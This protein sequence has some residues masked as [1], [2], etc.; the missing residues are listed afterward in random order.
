MLTKLRLNQRLLLLW[1]ASAAAVLFVSGFAYW[2]LQERQAEIDER[3]RIET[4]FGILG[5]H[6]GERA[7]RLATSA[8]ALAERASVVA[9]LRLFADYFDPQ[10]GAATFD[11]PA[12]E[13]AG[14]LA[15]LARA[16]GAG[17]AV[18]VGR[19]GP[20]SGYWRDDATDY[21]AYFSYPDTGVVAFSSARGD[22]LFRPLA[23]APGFLGKAEGPADAGGISMV[24]CPTGPGPALLAINPV[25]RSG[26]AKPDSLLGSVHVG[27]CLDREFIERVASQTDTAF[28]ILSGEQFTRSGDRPDSV[29]SAEPLPEMATGIPL[30]A[31]RWHR[32]HRRLVGAGDWLLDDGS[33]NVAQFTLDRADPTAQHHALITAGLSGLLLSGL[34]IFAIGLL[35]LRRTVTQPLQQ[36]MRAVHSARQG[37]YEAV[38]GIRPGDEIGDLA[39]TFN[40]MT[41]R[42]RRREEELRRLSRAVE[43]SPASVVITD[44]EGH[45][46]YVNPRFSEVTGYTS[47][48]VLGHKPNLLKSGH[49]SD[50]VYARLWQTILA[51]K[52]WRGELFNRTKDGTVICEQTSISPIFGEDGIITHFVAVNEDITQRKQAEAQINHLAYHDGLTDLPNRVLFRDRLEQALRLYRRHGVPFALLLLDLDHFKDINDSLGHT[53]GDG[54]LRLVARRVDGLLRKSDTFSRFGGDEFAILQSRISGPEDA[55]ALAAKVI[56]SFREPFAVGAMRLHSNSS[57]GIAIPGEDVTDADELISRADI[58][59]YK[60]KDRGRGGYVYFDDAMTEQVQRDAELTNDLAR[61]IGQGQLYLTFQPQVELTTG[62][63]VGAEA[64]LR[65]HHPQLGEIPPGRFIPLA[66]SRGLMPE[67]GLWVLTESCRQWLDWRDQGLAVPRIAVNVSATQFKGSYGFQGMLEAVERAGVPYD[68]LE[69]EF[70]ESAFMH[71]DADALAWIGTLSKRGVHFAIDDFGTGYSSLVMLRQFQANKLKIDCGFVRDMLHD[72][73]DAAIVQATISLA[74]SLGIV[75]VAEG[76]EHAAQAASLRQMGC[77]IGQGYHFARPMRPEAF[78]ARYGRA[79]SKML[80]E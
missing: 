47:E 26:S 52:V 12:Q 68:A 41:E 6:V 25:Y 55:A 1:F 4:A 54:M 67:I 60:A 59:L 43:Q 23:A 48:E 66:E 17:W 58:A 27:V 38:T 35:Y 15:E 29:P 76:I 69:I 16:A 3:A 65:W 62:A 37:R 49:M 45:I 61:A 73:N 21:R 7:N 63:L 71:V 51:G 70:T 44:P 64:L 32:D 2:S 72:A 46:E 80:M 22:S 50:E 42:I 75:T 19:Q 33:R 8:G 24:R 11:P 13:L 79:S 36:L 74:K 57:I 10:L 30:T 77:D 39:E 14:E 78:L 18:I 53:V 28:D 5:Q 56:D 20:L 9:T 34:G 31:I 40:H